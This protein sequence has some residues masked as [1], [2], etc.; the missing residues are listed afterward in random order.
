MFVRS[1]AISEASEV[2]QLLYTVGW[3]STHL[4]VS[5][6]LDGRLGIV[7]GQAMVPIEFAVAKTIV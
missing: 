2:L 4:V 7:L 5:L 3:Q 6:G 1:T